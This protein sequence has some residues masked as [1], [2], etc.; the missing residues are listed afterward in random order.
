[1]GSNALQFERRLRPAE[2]GYKCIADIGSGGYGR[3]YLFSRASAGSRDYVAGKFVYRDVF[4]STGND[5]SDSAYERAFEGLRRF[6][7]LTS[8]SPYLLRI[9]DV[10]QRLGYFCYFMELADDVVSGRAV[11]PRQY[12]PKSLKNELERSGQRR[13]L[14]VRRSLEIAVMLARG[15]QLLHHGGFTHRDVRPSNIIFV[16]GTPKLADID[17]LAD[18]QAALTSYIPKHYA[19]PEGSHSS[20]ADIFS[21]GKTLYEMT[22]GL[23]VKSFP[24]LP[25]DIR[26]W[27]DHKQF[28][29]MNKIIGK[30]CA[31]DLR[32]RYTSIDTL[33]QD[34]ESIA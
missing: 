5:G 14:P 21:F 30:A 9:F 7:S 15:L 25:P 2:P 19:A 18:E 11:D 31:R 33:L 23:P 13:R 20:R 28:L 16:N 34:L 1:M 8:E 32:K 12:K 29:A 26:H 27:T 6:R 17:L 10:R 4:E 22:T 24:S 3:V